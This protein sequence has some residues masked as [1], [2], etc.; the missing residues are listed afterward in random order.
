M[1]YQAAALLNDA[2]GN[3]FFQFFPG[4]VCE[5]VI[6]QV[7]QF[8]FVRGAYQAAGKGRGN[9]GVSQF[10]YLA[11]GILEGAVAVDHNFHMFAGSFQ[12]ALLDFFHQSLALMGEQF[13]LV[14]RGFVGPQQTVF[15][16]I[17]AAVHRGGHNVVQTADNFGAG[18]FQKAF[19]AG[20]GMDIAVQHFVRIFQDGFRMV[21]EDYFHFRAAG[22]HQLFI[23][24]HV[25]HAGE[26]MNRS[27][28][29]LPVFFQR[30]DI[31]ERIHA[32]FVNLIQA[33]QMV[34]YFIRGIA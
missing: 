9:N 30:Q 18:F 5:I 20:P 26:F 10:P 11:L 12:D 32:G 25:I 19:G 2:V 28:K 4:Q 33:Y 27:A 16:I 15:F 21:G 24:I 1:A 31:A 29:E 34:A 8:Q 17:A 13:Y 22:F 7:L 14:F 23:I 3:G 6:C